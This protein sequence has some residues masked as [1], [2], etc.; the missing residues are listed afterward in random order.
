MDSMHEQDRIAVTHLM[1]M[2]ELVWDKVEDGKHYL[3]RAQYDAGN[4]QV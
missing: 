4:E 3:S 2:P 1:D